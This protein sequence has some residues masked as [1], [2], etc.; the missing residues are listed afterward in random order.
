MLGLTAQTPWH[1]NLLIMHRQDNQ[2]LPTLDDVSHKPVSSSDEDISELR[3][4]AFENLAPSSKNSR[5]SVE[6]SP[7]ISDRGRHTLRSFRRPELGVDKSNILSTQF[8]SAASSSGP[9]GG[10]SSK[11]TFLA[12]HSGTVDEDER[13]EFWGSKKPKTKKHYG[14]G[15]TIDNING[16]QEAPQEERTKKAKGYSKPGRR[17]PQAQEQEN[18]LSPC[19]ICGNN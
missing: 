5:A 8:S 18:L 19:K 13:T 2:Q 4:G 15:R 1:G 12:T 9:S 14:Q 3:G 10:Q 17:K 16:S 6:T 7:T 11:R